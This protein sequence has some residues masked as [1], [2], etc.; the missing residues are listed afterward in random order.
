MRAAFKNKVEASG[1]E[2]EGWDDLKIS[3]LT[4]AGEVCG[5]NKGKVR[6]SE[7]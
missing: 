4:V 2:N 7:T 6:H 1:I 5:Y 3:L